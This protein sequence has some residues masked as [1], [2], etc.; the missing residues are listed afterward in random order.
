MVREAVRARKWGAHGCWVKGSRGYPFAV[1]E[2]RNPMH[3]HSNPAPEFDPALSAP[4]VCLA[5]G[6]LG[7]AGD[8]A[9]E[10]GGLH[11]NLDSWGGG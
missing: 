6:D 11:R 9:G 3:C 2:P 1:A 10:N 7:S 4:P 8:A 5:P